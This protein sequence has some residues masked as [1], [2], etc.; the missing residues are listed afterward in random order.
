MK[1]SKQFTVM[2]LLFASVS[3]A[4]ADS[5]KIRNAD[6]GHDYQRID[7][8]M[9]WQ[10]AQDKCASLD[11]YLVTLTSQS[12]EQFVIDHFVVPVNQH[13]WLGATDE[14]SE[15]NWG[16]ITKEPWPS[17]T[18]WNPG[19]PNNAC[20]GQNVL[21][22]FLDKGHSWDD[23]NDTASCSEVNPNLPYP[24]CEWGKPA[25]TKIQ[26]PDNQH[27][28]QLIEELMTWQQ[29]RDKCASLGG[30]L[31]TL[32]SQAEEQFVIDNFVV[33]ANQTIWVGATD[34][35]SEGHWEWITKEPWEYTHFPPGKPD[36]ACGGEDYL[37]MYNI[38]KGHAWD[39]LSNTTNVCFPE[40]PYQTYA[41]CEWESTVNCKATEIQAL[42]NLPSDGTDVAQ[43]NPDGSITFINQEYAMLVTPNKEKSDNQE[44]PM[45]VTP[46]ADCSSYAGNN[47]TA[48]ILVTPRKVKS[49]VR[50]NKDSFTV[51]TGKEISG[52]GETLSMTVTPKTDGSYS[53]A[54]SQ[55][56]TIST[57]L[58][59]NGSYTITDI[60]AGTTATVA[61]DG[62]YTIED[63][64]FSGMQATLNKDGS[65]VVKD[66]EFPGIMTTVNGDSYI[67]KDDAFP[68]V[69]V[70]YNA[71]GSYTVTDEEFP[72]LIGTFYTDENNVITDY[73]I[74]DSEG[75]C[76]VLDP[77]TRGFFKKVKKFVKKAAKVVKKVAT[78]VKKV[79]GAVAKVAGFV[80]KA[81]G[82]VKDTATFLI[83]FMPY[84][85]QF[86]C[87][88]AAFA[89]AV[90]TYSLTVAAFAHKVETFAAVVEQ[91]SGQV[92]ESPLLKRKPRTDN[93]LRD[94]KD[95]DFLYHPVN[96]INP[97]NCKNIAQ[98]PAPALCQLYAVNDAEL[99]NSQF[100]TVNLDDLKVNKLGPLYKGHDIE[101][102]TIHPQ[103]NTIYAAS[104]NDVGE[105][106][107]KGYLYIVDGE[108]GELFPIGSSGFN[109]IGDLA[110]APDGTLWA[111]AKNDG[112]ITIEP[113]TGLGTLQISSDILVEGLTLSKDKDRTVFF[114]SVNTELWVYDMDAD[115]LEVACTNLIGETEGL[116]I[117]PD[118]LLLIGT[119]KDKTFNI[120]AF[121]PKACQIVVEAELP[122]Y[123]FGD[124]EGI[125]L[126]V[127]ACAK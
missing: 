104:G 50:D 48:D 88:V 43:Q 59:P 89:G 38:D 69:T 80:A 21:L 58:N 36:E 118:G 28:Y 96:P 37:L 116:E 26:N 86:L 76:Y 53:I 25:T 78:V 46:L 67:I 9:T 6:N 124:V 119:H 15:G 27:E 66:D 110:F 33:P 47:S 120:H 2:V 75:I 85:C 20:G 68:G 111:W 57:I 14:N 115:S 31:V 113:T 32:T 49:G 56:P 90:E 44:S 29:S 17:Y 127:G 5:D 60:E 39:D 106:Q 123:Q 72:D 79:A 34:E 112:M 52:T 121:D 35:N 81:A 103:T 23:S 61:T 82:I 109:E 71:D 40:A 63:N 41:V 99:N 107:P 102:L 83:P 54:H 117:M 91:T 126:P 105:G 94:G 51:I 30:H 100:F 24:V 65:Y 10:Q 22:M 1:I 77:N 101:A 13:I 12:E 64:E 122:T 73:L 55:Y 4:F 95:L 19:E 7:E 108:T 3:V 125:A 92:A 11:G 62:R 114:G 8:P 42:A 45:V 74:T 18:H 93:R 16:W 98:S 70:N 87:T 97:E 84:A